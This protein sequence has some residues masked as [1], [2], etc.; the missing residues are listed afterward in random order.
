MAADGGACIICLDSSPPPI[1][2]GCACRGDSGLVH[3][4]C[5]VRAATS[6]QAQRGNDVWQKCQTCK[7]YYTGAMQ[8]G[9]AEAWRS[10][11]AGQAA[12][13]AERLAAESNLAMSLL[14]QGKAVEAEP[15]FQR[16]HEVEMRVLGAEH[17]NTLTSAGNLAT[18][19][20]GQ[21]KYAEAERIE[22]EVLGVRKRVLGAAHPY[23]LMS[24]GNLAESL[25]KQGKYAEAERIQREVLEVRKRV[26]GAEHPD[27]LM[28]AGN[29]A[30]SLFSQG[31][32]AD[33]E[34]IERESKTR[35]PTTD[36]LYQGYT[37]AGGTRGTHGVGYT[38]VGHRGR[39]YSGYSRGKGYSS[40][41]FLRA[42]KWPP[43]IV[44]PL[45]SLRSRH[46]DSWVRIYPRQF[47][48]NTPPKIR[49]RLPGP[50]GENPRTST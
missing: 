35:W 8:T 34:R 28:S 27:T 36:Q 31:K 9:L 25:S 24:A 40:T 49:I 20:F 48:S 5:L 2:S 47:S 43:K 10:R 16:L 14:D 32:Y 21:G 23:T 26:L 30:M 29:L 15:M 18:S 4:A 12:E 17:R 44:C 45:H 46:I 7:Q 3:I 19:L 41:H 22:R 37:G 39:G 33:A 38:G 50:P 1:Q 6:Q 13:S 42:Y 11:V